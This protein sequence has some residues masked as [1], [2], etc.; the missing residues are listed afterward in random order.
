MLTPHSSPHSLSPSLPSPPSLSTLEPLRSPS[1]SPSMAST[2]QCQ[3]RPMAP[4]AS[5]TSRCRL[6]AALRAL[7]PNLSAKLTKLDLL[8]PSFAE[9]FKSYEITS[10]T[11]ACPN[12]KQFLVAC[13]FDHRC[14]GF[15]SDETLLSISTN[16]PKLSVL[17]LVDL[18]ALLN[19]RGDPN[20][21]GFTA[22]DDVISIAA[23]I[24]MFTG[25]PML[26][27]LGVLG[28]TKFE[29]Q[30]CR[31]ITMR[32]NEDAGV[33]WKP[34]QDQIE[35]L[36][37]DCVWDSV[38]QFEA[39]EGVKYNFD[40][41][42]SRGSII[43][44]SWTAQTMRKWVNRRINAST[45]YDLNC[46]FMEGGDDN[47]N[48]IYGRTWDRL[49]R[50]GSRSKGIVGS[51]SKPSERVFGLSNL[52]R[53]PHLTK[54]H[55]DCG[56]TIGYAHTAPSGQMD[57][58]LWERFYLYGIG[59]LSLR[60]LDYWPPQDRD[61]NQITVSLPSAGLL[62]ECFTLRKLFIHGTAHEHFMK[63]LLRIPNMR[64]V[65][66]REDYYPAPE[67][68]MSTEMRLDSCSRFEDELNR[69]NIPD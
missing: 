60:E 69:R 68:D 14:I 63:F 42:K 54:M 3:A 16:C 40:L 39:L 32:G 18:S 50:F 35:W 24:D 7:P 19:P 41:N 61:V 44:T 34:V 5:N 17:H 10:I 26:E 29:V 37:I 57:L 13:M 8:N 56:D 43:P 20:V 49:R 62:G 9:G 1:L 66:L 6:R 67:N 30:G 11:S 55:L 33:R 25:L 23:L 64:D 38:E 52:V 48:G 28:W 51:G 58:S 59:H 53:Y 46:S 27:E 36:H 12:L 65:Q 4:T 45:S 2:D 22:E 21:E 31:K 47:G 15:V